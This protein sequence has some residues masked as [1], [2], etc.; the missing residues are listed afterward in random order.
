MR[1]SAVIAAAA[2]R[3]EFVRGDQRA[4]LGADCPTGGT[5]VAVGLRTIRNLK[6]CDRFEAAMTTGPV[7]ELALVQAAVTAAAIAGGTETETPFADTAIASL[8]VIELV[9]VL[10]GPTVVARHARPL[11]QTDIGA[12]GVVRR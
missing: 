1:F 3:I 5:A 2:I 10:H 6:R 4:A 11:I 8:A 12:A 9:G 7:A